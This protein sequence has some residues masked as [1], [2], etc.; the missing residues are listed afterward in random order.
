[1]T[2]RV[3]RRIVIALAVAVA[4]IAACQ[5]PVLESPDCSSARNSIREFYSFHFGNDMRP[6]VEGLNAQKRFLTPKLFESLVNSLDQRTD[7]FTSTVDDYPKAFRVGA[8]KSSDARNA[9]VE[10]LL[11]WKD[12]NR[13]EQRSVNVE[14]VKTEDRWLVSK[15]TKN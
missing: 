8:C 14:A 9:V 15:V 10:V 4:G 2:P 5:L 7:Y 1:M 11:F 13:S 6:S 3:S 12:D